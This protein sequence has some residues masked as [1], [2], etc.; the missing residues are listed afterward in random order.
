MHALMCVCVSTDR[1]ESSE[2]TGARC[3]DRRS[4]G[5]KIE[6]C[7]QH[8]ETEERKGAVWVGGAGHMPQGKEL[9]E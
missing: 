8:L 5:I 9:M 1:G 6:L 7:S 4:L 2:A 3:D